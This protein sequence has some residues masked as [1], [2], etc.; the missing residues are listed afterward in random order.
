MTKR[1]SGESLTAAK[2]HKP[3]RD[4]WMWLK[5]IKKKAFII[6]AQLFF[7][8][9]ISIKSQTT[10]TWADSSKW[11][12]CVKNGNEDVHSY[13]DH[14][15]RVLGGSYGLGWHTSSAG[16]TNSGQGPPPWETEE[17]FHRDTADNLVP[18]CAWPPEHLCFTSVCKTR[19]R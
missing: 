5:M 16:K 10:R 15:L 19:W 12:L 4:G 6:S 11:C 18:L 17:T 7:K 9:L 14:D 3:P 1:A 2:L 13:R 8:E